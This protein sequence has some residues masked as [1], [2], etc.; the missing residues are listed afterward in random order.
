MTKITH[1]NLYDTMS[2]WWYNIVSESEIVNTTD[3]SCV[4]VMPVNSDSTWT[5]HPAFLRQVFKSVRQI[6]PSISALHFTKNKFYN[7]INNVADIIRLK[8]LNQP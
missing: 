7:S 1:K 2:P 8:G 5:K 6:D 4:F 3:N